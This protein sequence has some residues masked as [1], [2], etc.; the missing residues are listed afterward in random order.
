MALDTGTTPQGLSGAAAIAEVQAY[1]NESTYP[2]PATTLLFLNNGLQEV[3]R[4]VG[5]IRLWAPYYTNNQQTTISLNADIQDIVSANF[6]MGSA[7]ASSN[8]SSSPFAQGALVYPMVAIEQAGFMDAAAGFPAVGFGPPQAYFVYQDQSS[9]PAQT[10]PPP[11]QVQLAVTS[12]T[13]AGTVI[14]VGQTYVNANGET[15]LGP[16][17]DITPTG[18]QQAQTI[19]PPSYQNATSYNVYAGAVGGPYHL[20]NATPVAL[21]TSFTIPSPLLAITVPPVTNTATG[22]GTGGALSMQLYPAAMIGQVNIY[23]RARPLLWADTT[24]N[25]YTN[26]DSSVQE[27]AVIWA[28]MRVLV[29]R[30]RA[31]EAKEIWRPE[32]DAM[33]Q[34]LKESINRRTIPKYAQVR[35]VANRSFP[36]SPFWLSR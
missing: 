27:A 12:G 20:Q 10:L 21:G 19:T 23:Y 14:E 31:A 29:N 6:S 9:A 35:D 36:S 32:F 17:A 16:V 24:A 3:C 30:Q 33:I 18:I 2:A 5:G 8:G 25:S 34:D 4:L 13:S 1:T 7:N 26:L 11:A 22:A 15:T 28:T